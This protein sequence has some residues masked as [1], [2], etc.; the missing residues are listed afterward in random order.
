MDLVLVP[1]ICLQS[2]HNNL[3]SD[4]KALLLQYL[5]LELI[6]SHVL[7][8]LRAATFSS[9]FFVIDV[10][11]FFLYAMFQLVVK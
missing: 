9:T 10:L 1:W 3:S 11:Y 4:V 8:P 7:L 6:A 5:T 2:F